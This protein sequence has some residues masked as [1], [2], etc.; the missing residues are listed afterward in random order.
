MVR[1]SLPFS[2][3]H[4]KNRP[5]GL[6]GGAPQRPESRR[7]LADRFSGE[8]VRAQGGAP[9]QGDRDGGFSTRNRHSTL[10][11]RLLGTG[12]DGA[13]A[14]GN[15]PDGGGGFAD[16][17]NRLSSRCQS[18]VWFLTLRPGAVPGLVTGYL[19]EAGPDCRKRP[20]NPD[21][22]QRGEIHFRTCRSN[23]RVLKPEHRACSHNP[24]K[25]LLGL[26][27]LISKGLSQSDDFRT[28][29]GKN[30]EYGPNRE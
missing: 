30:G 6:S 26:N 19:P 9:L 5:F 10:W 3:Y 28:R 20:A 15:S 14:R 13:G 1:D 16:T 8:A 11:P 17:H 25:R 4:S 22:D 2:G 18:V 24:R 7:W 29:S 27:P 21:S 12:W 23:S